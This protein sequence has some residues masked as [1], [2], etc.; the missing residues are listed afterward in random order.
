MREEELLVKLA[1]FKEVA[2]DETDVANIEE[3][4]AA[5][6]GTLV[7]LEA[8][9]SALDFSGRLNIRIPKSLHMKLSSEAKDDG[10][11]LNQY[12]I[13]KLSVN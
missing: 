1:G 3:A 10:V 2:P 12:I 4:R 6:D 7:P 8:V 13:Y 5:D 11:S 9:R